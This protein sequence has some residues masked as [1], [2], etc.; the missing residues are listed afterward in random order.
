MSLLCRDVAV[1]AACCVSSHRQ[2][3]DAGAA[4]L[5]MSGTPLDEPIASHGPFVMN[6]R[7]EIAK[8]FRDL[9]SG[10]F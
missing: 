7:E 1:C 2:A 4:V 5:V 6:T 10:E 8:A 3:L 9:Q